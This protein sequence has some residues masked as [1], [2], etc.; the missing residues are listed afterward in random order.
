MQK[1]SSS[2]IGTR[3]GCDLFRDRVRGVQTDGPGGGGGGPCG[4]TSERIDFILN[5]LAL[6]RFVADVSPRVGDVME[7]NVL[8]VGPD[9]TATRRSP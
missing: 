4:D 5:T 8:S 9:A 1:C 6:R 7:T 2:A 3:P